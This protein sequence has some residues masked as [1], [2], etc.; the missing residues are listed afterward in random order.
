MQ[1]YYKINNKDL[2]YFCSIMKWAYLVFI[3]LYP[4]IAWLI[5]PFNRKAALWVSGRKNLL[6]K[7]RTTFSGNQDPV[8]W[9]HAAS[10]GEFEQGL[11]IAE[12]LK[13]EY[14]GHRILITFFSP[15]GYENKKNHPV[16]DWVFYLPMDSARNAKLL[17]EY[18]RP[19]LAIFIK[20]EFWYYYLKTLHNHNIPV[21]LVSGIFR[22]TQLFFKPL[23]GF[24]RSLLQYF[25]H[26]F[27]QD[28][29]SAT[30]LKPFIAAERMQVS[31]DTRF[32]RVID[33][34]TAAKSF[35]EIVQFA[36]GLPLIIAGST[37]S[38]DD[39]VLHHFAIRHP[40]VKWIIAPHHIEE[41][42]LNECLRFYPSAV[43]Y[44]VFTKANKEEQQEAK[45]IVIDNIGILSQ[46]YQY[47][48]IAF[49][50]GG[51]TSQGIHNT[52][53]AAI[54]GKP[55]VFGPVYDKYLEAVELIETGGAATVETI[56]T[57]EE[58]FNAILQN[59][60]KQDKMGK[61]AK[62][63]VA[64]KAGATQKILHYIQANRLLT[65]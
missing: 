4:L 31:G 58:S 15:S 62:N 2:S 6:E 16:A 27:L 23:G 25:R 65:N 8:I 12:Q 45:T 46:L 13:K 19:K 34:A 56:L 47:A 43:L 41:D 49:I 14:P 61:A 17:I 30:L 48:T 7:I 42:R 10:L 53:E 21:L 20:Y 18:T 22:P 55:V 1:N 26:L 9:I 38:E 57:L 64:A 28:Q 24:Y 35:P 44:S 39:K 5:S 32:D 52:I 37:W 54:F 63:F 60:E 40:E 50:G 33:I 51:F 36:D 29:G 59:K 11:P 3:K